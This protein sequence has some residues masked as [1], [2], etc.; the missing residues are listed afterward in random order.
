MIERPRPRRALEV[1]L[2]RP[3]E[4]ERDLKPDNNMP[5]GEG[6]AAAQLEQD[7]D[8]E[9]EEI[10]HPK[11]KRKLPKHR[12]GS[13]AQPY[14]KIVNGKIVPMAKTNITTTEAFA[15]EFRA[16]AATYLEPGQKG[17]WA[18]AVLIRAMQKLKRKRE[19]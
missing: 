13:L 11:I 7:V 18:E 19:G 6:G 8:A 1:A 2:D 17:A 15:R 4:Q 3:L 12:T 9:L 16:F 10:A 5:A 14:P